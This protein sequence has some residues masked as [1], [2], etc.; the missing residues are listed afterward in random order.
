[1]PWAS[2]MCAP[3]KATKRRPARKSSGVG[4]QPPSH[5]L[6]PPSIQ[7]LAASHMPNALTLYTHVC[8]CYMGVLAVQLIPWDS[9]SDTPFY[10]PIVRVMEVPTTKR[11]VMWTAFKCLEDWFKCIEQESKP[12]FGFVGRQPSP[13]Q[14]II[15]PW[16]VVPAKK[17]MCMWALLTGQAQLAT[18]WPRVCSCRKWSLK[19]GPGWCTLC[20][21]RASVL[22]VPF[23]S[24]SQHAWQFY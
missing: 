14:S 9:T 12:A 19:L 11:F 5:H 6:A 24:C 2:A 7:R 18:T 17:P 10:V 16:V 3:P 13:A 1:M 22:Q 21:R 8:R 15:K 20:R 23:F 4:V